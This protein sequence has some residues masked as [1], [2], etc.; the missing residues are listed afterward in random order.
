[1]A[2]AWDSDHAVAIALD[3]SNAEPGD[4]GLIVTPCIA[5]EAYLREHRDPVVS[6]AVRA[7]YARV[8]ESRAR[9]SHSQRIEE[10]LLPVIQDNA[11]SESAVELLATTYLAEERGGQRV[12]AL[13]EQLLD[14]N[15]AIQARACARHVELPDVRAGLMLAAYAQM[16]SLTMA[17]IEELHRTPGILDWSPSKVMTCSNGTVRSAFFNHP[18]PQA[19]ALYAKLADSV[20]KPS[21]RECFLEQ[22]TAACLTALMAGHICRAPQAPARYAEVLFHRS[23]HDYTVFMQGILDEKFRAYL[24]Y[25]QHPGLED[26]QRLL[27]ALHLSLAHL[28]TVADRPQDGGNLWDPAY[29]IKQARL[30]YRKL[31]HQELPDSF[32]PQPRG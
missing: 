28:L 32:L 19:A 29:H 6:T 25:T 27:L 26:P 1:M 24:T 20:R 14:E 15:R 22:A 30:F 23:R 5:F 21:E 7:A 9:A 12:I 4:G 17:D 16:P 31:Y 2:A 11:A 10:L 8:L 3:T 13:C 18:H